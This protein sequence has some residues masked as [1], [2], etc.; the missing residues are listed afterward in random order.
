MIQLSAPGWQEVGL[1][2][3]LAVV[4]LEPESARKRDEKCSKKR[5]EKQQNR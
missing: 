1:S 2:E 4:L 5:K 3:P